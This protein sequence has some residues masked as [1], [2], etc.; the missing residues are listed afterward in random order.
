M[1]IIIWSI[2]ALCSFAGSDAARK[3]AVERVGQWAELA[4]VAIVVLMFFLGAVAISRAVVAAI[5]SQSGQ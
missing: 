3:K 1:A 4:W 5:I 2:V